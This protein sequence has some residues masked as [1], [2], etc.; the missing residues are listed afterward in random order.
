MNAKLDFKQTTKHI[1]QK[2]LRLKIYGKY[3]FKKII[4]IKL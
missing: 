4:I 3:K 2:N 1:P